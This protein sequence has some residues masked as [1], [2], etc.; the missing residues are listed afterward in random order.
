MPAARTSIIGNHADG[1]V[2]NN[3]RTVFVWGHRSPFSV[4]FAV[5]SER[6]CDPTVGDLNNRIT[7]PSGFERSFAADFRGRKG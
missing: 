7:R 3:P 4:C 5:E 6:L 1:T 2:V